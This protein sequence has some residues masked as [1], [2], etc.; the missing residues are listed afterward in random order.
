MVVSFRYDDMFA[1]RLVE[2]TYYLNCMHYVLE[3]AWAEIMARLIVDSNFVGEYLDL[4]SE[5]EEGSEKRNREDSE[6][7][8]SVDMIR[9]GGE[10][11]VKM[12]LLETTISQI[13]SLHW[14]FPTPLFTQPYECIKRAYHSPL[15]RMWT[16]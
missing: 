7:S 5:K 13:N 12:D 3:E 10:K 9:N 15:K 2:E 11:Y 16:K 14:L 8:D 4:C 1:I 6:L